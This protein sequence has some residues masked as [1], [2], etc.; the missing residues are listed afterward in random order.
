MWAYVEELTVLELNSRLMNYRQRAKKKQQPL[1]E[2]S[3]EHTASASPWRL[4][5]T[6]NIN[7]FSRS[8]IRKGRREQVKTHY[9]LKTKFRK[10][11]Q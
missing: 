11:S 9:V 10:S 3:L 4:S 5:E 7:R 6:T 8:F 1:I 2:V